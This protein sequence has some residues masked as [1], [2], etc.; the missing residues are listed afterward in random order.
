M[1]EARTLYRESA[2]GDASLW[3]VPANLASFR[4]VD[5]LVEWI[6]TEQKQTV[7]AEAKV[8]K[9]AFVADLLFPFA[10]PPA[11]GTMDQA[12]PAFENQARVMLWGVERL[13]TGLAALGSDTA[14]DHRLHAVLPG[15][16]NRG[17]FGGDGAYGE[18]KAGLEAICNKWRIGPWGTRTTLAHALIGWVRGTGLM[19]HNDPL[20][21]AVEDNG[22]RTF[23]TAEMA[24]QLI[25]LASADARKKAGESPLIADLT[26]GLKSLDFAALTAV[27]R[28]ADISDADD[29]TP[30]ISA[31]PTPRVPVAAGGAEAFGKIGMRPEEMVVIVGV[32]E[33]GPWGS[34]RTRAGA[35]WGIQADGDVELTA[36]G[37]L[38]LAWMMGLITWHDTPRAGWYDAQDNFVDESDIYP[39]FRNEVV[40]RA[41]VRPICDHGP[42]AKGG[43]TDV[44][45]VFLDRDVTFP[46]ANAA[47]AEAFVA[48]D[49][50]FTTAEKA[51][52]HW[53]ITRRRGAKV[54]VPRR[55]TLKRSVVGQ[56]PEGFDPAR[57]G[58]PASLIENS[59]IMAQWNLVATVD[60][61]LTAGFSP[62][63]LLQAVHPADVGSTQGT[64]FGGMSSMRKLFVDRFLS[65]D[66]PQDI[67][68]ETLPNVIAAHAMQSYVSGYGPM[69][70]PVA[71]CASA[72]VSLEEGVDKIATGKAEFV[73]TGAIDDMSVESLEGFGNMNAT[74]AS[75]DLYDKGINPRFFSRAGDQRRAGF[76]EAQGGGTVLIARGDVALELGLPVYAVVG[77]VQTFADGAHTS[78]PA[79]GLG[80]LAAGRG[81]Q[82]S[83]LARS[84]AA[85]GVDAD[86]IAVVSK[87][88][89]STLAN[90][91]NEAEL[92][93]RLAEALGRSAGNP[94]YVI[95]QKSLTGHSKGGAALFQISGLVQL[96]ASGVVPANRALDNLDP[97]FRQ[98][99]F[100]VWPRQPLAVG[101]NH[102]IKA[103]LATSLGFGH[104]SAVIALVHPG[105]FEAAVQRSQGASAA[106]ALA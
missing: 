26:G 104:V 100:L 34:A 61:F 15:S 3:L 24:R 62:A 17:L 35:E 106:R 14:V 42:I 28:P 44:V 81:G 40:A 16:P 10:A 55:T 101:S 102:P 60:A 33:I 29:D 54:M 22:V 41:G 9:P 72:A 78:I 19:A 5:K 31:L 27:P 6:G 75:Q 65:E 32:G 2:R 38:E 77:Y 25:D 39:R 21:A 99:Q 98:R 91:P 53:Q 82:K 79:P 103:A 12:G 4:D 1:L 94:L 70:Q 105:A 67:L 56:L 11:T 92:H 80:A 84:L 63:E 46:V 57:W 47:E 64:G 69:V 30:V 45:T 43:T 97:V 51:G 58:L 93:E 37:V 59:D 68:Q 48:A 90:D 85:L 95:S 88:D 7:G 66:I 96:F 52:D 18:I 13:L 49:P 71:A 83:R 73:V 36:A 8:V 76:V 20:V 23:S 89:T 86:D 74:A 87:H 50:D